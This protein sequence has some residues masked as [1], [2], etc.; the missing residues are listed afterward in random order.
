MKA[1]V[2][3]YMQTRPVH[4]KMVELCNDLL[5]TLSGPYQP[6]N[7]SWATVLQ[8]KQGAA[9]TQKCASSC[10]IVG[11]EGNGNAAC[12]HAGS[13]ANGPPIAS[14]F[15]IFM[16]IGAQTYLNRLVMTTGHF[17]QLLQVL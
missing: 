3:C 11:S 16:T 14:Q 5:L 12:R 15:D 17:T 9:P 8:A 6:S 1:W 2:L 10:S 7:T 4:H 13:D